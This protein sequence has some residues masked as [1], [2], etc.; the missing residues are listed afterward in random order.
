MYIVINSKIAM[1]GARAWHH[2]GS[3]T[4]TS[5]R[6]ILLH[7]D[8]FFYTILRTTVTIKSS[9]IYWLLEIKPCG[10]GSRIQDMDVEWR[11]KVMTDLISW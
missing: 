8:Q 9:L 10:L 5:P 2:H 4:P 3:D 7:T 6:A 1:L 11:L